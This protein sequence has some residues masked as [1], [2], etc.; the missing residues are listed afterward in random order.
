MGI[1]MLKKM[2]WRE[3]QEI[4]LKLSRGESKKGIKGIIFSTIHQKI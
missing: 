1:R 2:G 4:G 3:G